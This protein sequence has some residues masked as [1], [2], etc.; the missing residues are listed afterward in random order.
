MCG[1]P[2]GVVPIEEQIEQA[3]R[4]LQAAIRGDDAWRHHDLYAEDIYP[5]APATDAER[6]PEDEGPDGKWAKRH[7][8]YNERHA[9]DGEPTIQ[10]LVIEDIQERERHGVRTYGRAIYADTPNDPVEGGPI[11]Q[12]YREALDLV[13]YLRW[14]IERHGIEL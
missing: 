5:E 10:Q 12:A 4:N 11:G 2:E 8:A 3:K 1:L 7:E 6:F 13:I 14:F 9:D